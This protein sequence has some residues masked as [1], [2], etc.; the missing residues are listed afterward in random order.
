MS[1]DRPSVRIMKQPLPSILDEIEDKVL[2]AE[3]A[4][5]EATKA[6]EEAKALVG[7]AIEGAR[8]AA[9][10]IS[11]EALQA[12]RAA[13]FKG[14]EALKATDDLNERYNKL[15]G[16]LLN[17]SNALIAL[18]KLIHQTRVTF[19]DSFLEKVSDIIKNVN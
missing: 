2:R 17:T 6:K 14:A 1:V 5:A 12:A 15:S 8:E 4:A 11:S 16:K 7:E 19:S 18:A 13:E 9:K 3:S 10:V